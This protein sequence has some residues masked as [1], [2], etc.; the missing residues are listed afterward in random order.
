MGTNTITSLSVFSV[1]DDCDNSN[2]ESDN[3][4]SCPLCQ[5]KFDHQSEME[6]HAMS[7]H[8]V[9]QEGLQRLQSLINGSHWLNQNQDSKRRSKSRDDLEDDDEGRRKSS[10]DDEGKIFICLHLNK[11]HKVL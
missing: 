6:N 2:D 8:S 11:G 5:E 4:V 10:P 7:V 9:N 3:S 1:P